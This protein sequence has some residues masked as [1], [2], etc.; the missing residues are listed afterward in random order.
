MMIFHSY[1]SLPE[2]NHMIIGDTS[3]SP[4]LDGKFPYY[5]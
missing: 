4:L 3:F 2:G 5:P 1:A